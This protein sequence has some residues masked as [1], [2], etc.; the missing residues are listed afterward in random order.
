PRLR[1]KTLFATHYHELV[2]LASFLPRVKNFNVAVTEEGGKVIFL[3]KVV[4]GGADKSYGIH[5]AQLAGLPMSVV[6]RAQEVLAGLESSHPRRKQYKAARSKKAL[7]QQLPLF[8][9]KSPLVDEISQLD[10][11]SMSPL[12]AISK[13]YELRQKAK[14]TGLR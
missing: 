5:V 8:G 9:D 4:P 13:L 14:E 3:R 6:H 12:E 10:I 7:A 2:E 11:D 1:S